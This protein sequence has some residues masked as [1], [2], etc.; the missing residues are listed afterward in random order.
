MKHCTDD[1]FASTMRRISDANSINSH[2]WDVCFYSHAG[3]ETRRWCDIISKIT[4]SLWFLSLA[5][6]MSN[7]SSLAERA[8]GTT[9]QENRQTG[10]TVIR[11]P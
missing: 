6:L 8:Q 9:T 10:K 2:S 7:G 5:D 3:C 11:Q 1:G 4:A